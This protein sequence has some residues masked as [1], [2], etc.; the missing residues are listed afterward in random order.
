M[1]VRTTVFQLFQLS[2]KQIL[3]ICFDLETQQQSFTIFD[4]HA[5]PY[6]GCHSPFSSYTYDKCFKNACGDRLWQHCHLMLYKYFCMYDSSNHTFSRTKITSYLSRKS[7]FKGIFKK[8]DIENWLLMFFV[9]LFLP[10]S[11][12]LK[13]IHVNFCT[14]QE[15]GKEL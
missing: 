9:C 2:N 5:L 13:V 10:R 3:I 8:F 6:N 7:K 11:M 12:S 1:F 4:N 15:K 14:L